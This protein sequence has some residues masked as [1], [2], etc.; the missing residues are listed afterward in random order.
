MFNYTVCLKTFEAADLIT[1]VLRN[2]CICVAESVLLSNQFAT[3]YCNLLCIV[4]FS[5]VVLV[6]T[7][8]TVS[9]KWDQCGPHNNLKNAQGLILKIWRIFKAKNNHCIC[10]TFTVQWP[11]CVPSTVNQFIIRV[12]N[13]IS[14]ITAAMIKRNVHKHLLNVISS[15]V[16]SNFSRQTDLA[17]VR[18][19]RRCVFTRQWLHWNAHGTIMIVFS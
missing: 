19:E 1:S 3:L 11:Q 10:S 13:I 16:V 14:Y 7:I 8:Q 17:S 15:T 2:H 4:K 9:N 18:R 6:Y 5:F 12:F